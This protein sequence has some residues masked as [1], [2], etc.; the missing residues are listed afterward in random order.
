MYF[1]ITDDGINKII[2]FVPF[3]AFEKFS[4]VLHLNNTI[5]FYNVMIKVDSYSVSGEERM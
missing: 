5:N 2:I 4:E 1:E 3:Y